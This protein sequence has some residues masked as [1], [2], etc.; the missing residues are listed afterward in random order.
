[1]SRF[2]LVPIAAAGLVIAGC[3][4]ASNLPGASAAPSPAR[5]VALSSA[6]VSPCAGRTAQPLN[7]TWKVPVSGV[8]RSFVVHVPASYDPSKPTPL[9]LNFHGYRMSPKLEDWLTEMSAKADAAGFVVV[10][11][12]GVGSPTSFNAGI[13]CGSA[14]HDNVDDV[15]FTGAMLD[16]LEADLCI[17]ARRVYATGMSNGGFM[18]H[19][20]GCAMADRIAAIAPVA[21]V[22]GDPICSPSRPVP[23][24]D[25]HGT[26]D[27]TVPYD[28]D[29]KRGWLSA[30]ASVEGWAKRDGCDAE[31]IES[32]PGAHVRCVTRNHCQ[33]GAEVTLCTVEGAGHTWPGGATVP[34][35]V[36]QGSTNHE[37][38]ADDLIWDFFQK[39][40]MPERAQP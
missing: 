4:G 24:L 28:G 12:Q 29:A 26:D 21:G 37:V 23:V 39:H 16:R 35:I 7:S 6:P 9:V 17:D 8:E 36:A 32:S 20:L 3:Y 14:A 34:W 1:M 25:F 15:A 10:Y 18:S 31:R 5:T 13:C 38:S 11:P 40:P 33:G 2:L 19:R 27:P 30:P 22:N